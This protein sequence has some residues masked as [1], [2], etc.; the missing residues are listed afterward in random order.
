MF[1]RGS[2]ILLHISSLPSIG[3]IGDF[4]PAAY[5]FVDF[6]NR[7]DQ[8]YWQLLPLNPTDP[9]YGNTP[10]SSNSAFA[11]SPLFISLELLAG[12][13]LLKKDE[14]SA[15]PVLPHD[16]R[17][18]Y[19]AAIAVKG[20]LLDR[21]FERFT[22]S[23]RAGKL[24]ADFYER[25]SFWLDDYAAFI[26]IKKNFNGQMWNQWPAEIRDRDPGILKGLRSKLAADLERVKFFQYL[27]WQQWMALKAYCRDKDVALIG[28]LPIYVNDDSADVWANPKIF[29]LD[30]NCEPRFVAGV[31][32][33]YF[34]ETGQRW[35]NPLYDWEKLKAHGYHWWIDRIRR[36]LELFDIVRI[37][38]F[39]GFLGYWQIPASEKT[40]VNGEWRPGPGDSFFNAIKK[41]WPQLPIIAEDLGIITPDVHDAMQRFGFPGMKVLQFAFNGDAANPYLPQNYSENSIVYTGTHDN[42][43]TRGWFRKDAQPYER[44]NLSRYLQKAV[45]ENSVAWDLI[46]LAM[47]SVAGI[48]IAPMQDVLALAE[49][50]RMNVP[51]TVSNNWQWRL[52]NNEI[53]PQLA[54]QL[55][56]LARTTQRAN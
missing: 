30:E 21:A 9:I 45:D 12:E 53:T 28:D 40:A 1:K 27:L 51:G 18:D 3:G 46:D 26:A 44:E 29:Q 36:N 48:A 13:G 50:S 11:V 24:Y 4:G 34:S 41:K 6:L 2:G 14:L 56:R 16:D 8:S 52:K 35:G 7:A 49:D 10:Y 25:N 55:A 5:D 38:H 31:P 20:R 43:T 47:K 42:N 17:V 33:D 15:V 39:R 19:P 37:D 22:Q 54:P 23:G 32:P